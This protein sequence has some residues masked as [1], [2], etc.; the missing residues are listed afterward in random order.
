MN[1][2]ST[3]FHLAEHV[4]DF[5]LRPRLTAKI[6]ANLRN[7]MTLIAAP[8]GA[9]KTS[10][11]QEWHAQEADRV[12]LAWLAL[13]AEDNDPL[14]FLRY[15]LAAV[16]V[17]LPSVAAMPE[18]LSQLSTEQAKAFLANFLNQIGRQSQRVVM[19]LD[20][21]HVIEN[22]NIHQMMIF[23]L[24]YMPQNL[25]LIL[26]TRSDPPFPLSRLRSR[27]QLLEIRA[28]DLRF[29]LEE[30]NHFLNHLMGFSLQTEQIATIE[31]RTEGWIVGIQLAALWLRS[32]A[33]QSSFISAFGGS[34]RYIADYLLEEVFDQLDRPTQD[35]LLCTSILDRFC[36]GLCTAVTDYVEAS[37]MIEVLQNANLFVIALDDSNTW[38]R[39]HHLFADLLQLRLRR[40][41]SDLADLY[42]RASRWCEQEGL[43]AEA[44]QYAIRGQNWQSA[45]DLIE[46]H[47]EHFWFRGELKQLLS[48]SDRLP[49]HIVSSSVGLCVLKAWTMLPSGAISQM[50]DY[51]RQAEASLG[52]DT[53]SVWYG[54]ILSLRAFTARI[55]EGGERG[56]TLTRKAKAHLS[57]DDLVWQAFTTMN[58]ASSAMML[59]DI[60]AFIQ[61]NDETRALSRRAGDYHTAITSSSARAQ[62]ELDRG[63]LAQ[64]RSLLQQMGEIMTQN[65]GQHTPTAGFIHVIRGRLSYE[66]W[67]LPAAQ[68]HF[69]LALQHGHDGQVA[70]III[71]GLV[72][73]ARQ[74][75]D[76]LT[77]YV[78]AIDVGWARQIAEA[79]SACHSM[80]TGDMSAV[81]QWVTANEKRIRHEPIM[82]NG[83]FHTQH[84]FL[85]RA[86][87]ELGHLEGASE[88]LAQIEHPVQNFGER[89]A[90][91]ARLQVLRVLL[92]LRQRQINA[93]RTLLM[94][95]VTEFPIT[96]FRSILL[97]EFRALSPLRDSIPPT[98]WYAPV[99]LPADRGNTHSELL[100]ALSDRELEVL[101]CLP[102]GLSNQAMADQLYI[103][104]NTVKWHLKEI[105]SKLGAGNRTQAIEKARALGLLS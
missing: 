74:A 23:L 88:H 18:A 76:D 85:I 48:W 96:D 21:Y 59:G 10:L 37:R 25:H 6:S 66:Q 105:Y 104:I 80:L 42:A 62:L 28:D 98:N 77:T 9:G 31:Q 35:F 32:K 100:D 14:R 1:L 43:F 45:A 52:D 81:R 70:D 34:N 16:Q 11:I 56:F 94:R 29:T 92:A 7:K 78:S 89:S 61:A 13:D 26:T 53:S 12:L 91:L 8:A 40:S 2:I 103:S 50:E 38:Y 71:D 17:V 54:R 63:H 68:Q 79:S 102:A 51:L 84:F 87:I 90:L 15:L 39:Y 46:Q 97:E 24:D 5:V 41:R 64:A 65:H 69:D 55:H 73:S 27:Q 83:W 44:I 33:D 60:P 86:C 30:T 82:L 36:A 58:L 99:P 4:H 93:A 49:P 19:A 67:D 57:P 72:W 101:R 3:K 75:L 20:D 22:R 47:S 95:L